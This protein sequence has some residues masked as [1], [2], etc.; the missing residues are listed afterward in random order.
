MRLGDSYQGS[1]G[2]GKASSK[3]S[4]TTEDLKESGKEQKQQRVVYNGCNVGKKS[5]KILSEEGSW[6]RVKLTNFDARLPDDVLDSSLRDRMK[7]CKCLSQELWIITSWQRSRISIQ[8]VMDC[9]YFVGKEIRK[10]FWEM[11][12]WMADGRGEDSDLPRRVFVMLC[13]RFEVEHAK[14]LVL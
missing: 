5:V 6:K 10:G 2:Q 8:T 4:L 9:V 13:N 7:C 1:Q 12:E 14:I 3:G 11:E